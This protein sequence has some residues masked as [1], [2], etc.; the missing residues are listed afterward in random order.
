MMRHPRRRAAP[1]ADLKKVLAFLAE[2][3]EIVP[4]QDF[5][6]H[7]VRLTEQ[8][9]PG[10][11][12]GFDEITPGGGYKLSHNASLSTSEER[13]YFGVLTQFYDQNPVHAH[14]HTPGAAPV[15]RISDLASRRAFQDT[16][17]YR[18]FFRHLEIEAQI[19][20]ILPVRSGSA[21]LSISHRY[22]FDD[23]LVKLF[24]LLA[25]HMALAHG[26]ALRFSELEQAQS[27]TQPTTGGL[28]TLREEEVLHW[29][30]EGKRNGEIAI[31]LGISE[32]TIEKHVENIL[33][34]L[35]VETRSAAALWR[36]CPRSRVPQV[37]RDG[38]HVLSRF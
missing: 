17:L 38:V 16:D 11:L 10:V 30:R 34:K 14:I 32:R 36:S 20:V 12:V 28:L 21:S 2:L 4:A 3:H 23:E 5:G 18:Q 22:D 24:R 6:A 19:H 15:A 13:H 7:L 25:P 35:R 29:I 27:Q 33:A 26:N 1:Q 8:L 37:A 31:I 9:I